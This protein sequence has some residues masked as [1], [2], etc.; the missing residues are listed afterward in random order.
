MKAL[1]LDRDGIINI[2]PPDGDYVMKDEDFVFQEGLFAP[3]AVL[4]ARGFKFFVIS[5][6]RC[7]AKGLLSQEGL[8]KLHNKM[9]TGFADHGLRIEGIYICPHEEGLCDCRKPKPGLIEQACKDFDID[10][11]SSYLLGNRERDILAGL[12]ANVAT[13]ILFDPSGNYEDKTSDYLIHDF[14]QLLD[15]VI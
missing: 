4:Q 2:D 7:L 13:N 14:N 11:T 15:I 10:L 8:E 6:Q 5:N 1:F 3:L 12:A 9:R